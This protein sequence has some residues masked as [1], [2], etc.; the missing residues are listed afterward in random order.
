[1]MNSDVTGAGDDVQKNSLTFMAISID[2]RTLYYSSHWTSSDT[3][4]Q[5]NINKTI[6]F[7]VFT[8]IISLYTNVLSLNKIV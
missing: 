4:K 1:M 6:L 8:F 5:L 3:E 7:K 2:F